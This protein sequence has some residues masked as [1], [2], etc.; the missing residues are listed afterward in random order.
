MSCRFRLSSQSYS[1]DDGD[2]FAD[3]DYILLGTRRQSGYELRSILLSSRGMRT[4]RY[5]PQS[6]SLT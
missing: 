2:G 3:I 1:D 6:G 4:R 5:K